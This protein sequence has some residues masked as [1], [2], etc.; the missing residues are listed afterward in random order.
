MFGVPVAVVLKLLPR[1]GRFGPL[2]SRDVVNAICGH[3]RAPA[4]VYAGHNRHVTVRGV[5]LPERFKPVPLNLV[6]LGVG[7]DVDQR[8]FQLDT[9]EFL[10]M[11][12]Y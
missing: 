10:D 2:S 4:A 1:A 12:A 9:F 5:R 3:H 11:D 7:D 8:T 6:I